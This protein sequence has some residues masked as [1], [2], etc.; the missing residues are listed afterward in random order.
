MPDAGNESPRERGYYS[1]IVEVFF[2]L[3]YFFLVE[4]A[5]CSEP[6]VRESINN[7][8]TEIIGDKI[9]DAGAEISAERGAEDNQEDV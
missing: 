5:E 1:V 2:T 4:H 6:T 3:F 7:R 9:V 8:T